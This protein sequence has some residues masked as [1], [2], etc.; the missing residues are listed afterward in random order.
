MK[1]WYALYVFLYSYEN[2]DTDHRISPVSYVTD[3]NFYHPRFNNTIH[4]FMLV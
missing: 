2:S 4:K 1:Q 3:N